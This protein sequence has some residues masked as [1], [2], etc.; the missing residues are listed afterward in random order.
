MEVLLNGFHGQDRHQ[1]FIDRRRGCDKIIQIHRRHGFGMFRRNNSKNQNTVGDMVSAKNWGRF[2]CRQYRLWQPCRFETTQCNSLINSWNRSVN[3]QVRHGD[4]PWYHKHWIGVFVG[5]W[6]IHAPG[7]PCKCEKFRTIEVLHLF[8]CYT[9]THAHT[10]THT[11]L[12]FVQATVCDYAKGSYKMSLC[13]KWLW[14]A[15]LPQAII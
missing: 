4:Q 14:P 5:T 1:K 7:A 2:W 3:W 15:G 13:T 12:V 6:P 10:H 9:H 11:G 8:R